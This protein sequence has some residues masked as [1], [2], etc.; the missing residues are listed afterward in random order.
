MSQTSFDPS[1][2]NLNEL[3]TLVKWL[4]QKTGKD[5]KVEQVIVVTTDNADISSG[6]DA[7]RDAMTIKKTGKG[8]KAQK[9]NGTKAPAMGPRFWRIEPT[10]EVLSRQKLNARVAAGEIE[11]L[12]NV[13]NAAGEQYVVMDGE[14]VK[15]PK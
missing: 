1:K 5:V 7:L 4:R 14:L 11:N 2:V 13:Y 9:S 6:L 10:G 3:E 8:T 15:G 12:T